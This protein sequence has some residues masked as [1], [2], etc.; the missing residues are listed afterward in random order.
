MRSS[1]LEADLDGFRARFPFPFLP[2]FSSGGSLAGSRSFSTS[3]LFS[4]FS[5]LATMSAPMGVFREA[6]VWLSRGAG[7]AGAAGAVG[8]TAAVAVLPAAALAAGAARDFAAA[9]VAAAAMTGGLAAAALAA[10]GFK[11]AALA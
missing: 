11:R 8:S 5:P 7:L 9:A 1:W 4:G 10:G 6:R 2:F 3:G